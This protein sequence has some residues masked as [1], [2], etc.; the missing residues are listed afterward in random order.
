MKIFSKIIATGKEWKPCIECNKVFEH[1]EILCSISRDDR[2]YVTYWYCHLCTE[3]FFGRELPID[4][5]YRLHRLV[6]FIESKKFNNYSRYTLYSNL[7]NCSL[8]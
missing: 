3:R 7:G 5:D 6:R 8:N 2:L 1:G 4:H